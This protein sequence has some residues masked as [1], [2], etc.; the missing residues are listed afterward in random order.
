MIKTLLA[1]TAVLGLMTGAGFA[2]T[3]TT[4]STQSTT[5]GPSPIGGAVLN[6]TSQRT[7]DSNGVVTD[8]TKTYS[9]G[10]AI[11]PA[12]DLATTRKTTETTVVH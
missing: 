10:T 8:Q 7:V 5:S 4:T 6:S 1:A 12:G 11:T 3:T 2:Q 9:A